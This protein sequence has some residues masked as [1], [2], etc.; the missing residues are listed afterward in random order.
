MRLKY[1]ETIMEGSVNESEITVLKF[2]IFNLEKKA[3]HINPNFNKGCC[4]IK[5]HTVEF[6]F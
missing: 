5:H 6:F 1:N 3:I 4:C 2:Y